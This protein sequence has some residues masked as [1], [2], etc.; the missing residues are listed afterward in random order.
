MNVFT[1]SKAPNRWHYI[2]R[3]N[4]QTYLSRFPY[5]QDQSYYAL[6][7]YCHGVITIV[8]KAT[9][10]QG[11][12]T[13]LLYARHL[14]K[15][16]AGFDT[17]DQKRQECCL[18]RRSTKAFVPTAKVTIQISPKK[19]DINALRRALTAL[20]GIYF[21]TQL[22]L[23]ILTKYRR[24]L[25]FRN[26]D[27]FNFPFA[28]LSLVKNLSLHGR[29]VAHHFLLDC[30]LRNS[31]MFSVYHKQILHKDG[32]MNGTIE[33]RLD[34]QVIDKSGMIYLPA[35]IVESYSGREHSIGNFRVYCRMFDGLVRKE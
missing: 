31:V 10:K 24:A 33:L 18:L 19:I 5:H 21:S 13:S 11:Q 7:P 16:P 8:T 30:V 12:V 22:T 17:V 1:T 9:V 34:N 28:L 14:P 6:C 29:L 32:S 35:T 20:T 25:S 4:V 23:A 15:A 3:Q 27:E 2:T 26:V